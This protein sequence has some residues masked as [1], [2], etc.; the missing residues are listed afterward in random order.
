MMTCQRNMAGVDR[1][2]L[3]REENEIQE[4][5]NSNKGRNEEGRTDEMDRASVLP[6]TIVFNLLLSAYTLTEKKNPPP[7]LF[8][9]L[10]SFV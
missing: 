7:L 3:I 5:R 8:P 9:V 1:T 10:L 6:L 4:K 2:R